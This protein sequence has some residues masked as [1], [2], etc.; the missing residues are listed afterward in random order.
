MQRLDFCLHLSI[1][2][3]H[4]QLMFA[5]DPSAECGNGLVIERGKIVRELPPA[6][7]EDRDL[8]LQI[9]LHRRLQQRGCPLQPG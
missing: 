9:G 5:S 8:A 2:E 3:A 4:E 7:D 6:A 1:A